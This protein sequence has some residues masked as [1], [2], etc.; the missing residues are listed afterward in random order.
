MATIGQD[1]RL[2][3]LSGGAGTGKSAFAAWLAHH[4]KVNV[5]GINL[6]RY[7]DDDRRDA[8]RVHP[9]ARLPDRDPAAGLSPAAARPAEKPGPRR[10]G[11][12][13]QEPRRTVCLAAG[14]AAR[15]APSTA[16]AARIA[17]WSSSMVS[18]RRCG[19]DAASLRKFCAADAQKLPA[20]IAVVVTSRPEEPIMRQFAGLQPVQI[21]AEVGGEP[22]GSA[23]LRPRMAG[24]AQPAGGA[25]SKPSRSHRERLRKAISFTCACCARR[26]RTGTLS[27]DTPE[28]LPQG[29]VG[30]YERWFRAHFPIAETYDSYV[31]LLAVIVAAEHPGPGAMADPDVR[32]VEARCGAHAGRSR[33]PVRAPDAG[34]A[35]F[36]KSLRDWL[37]DPK[38]AGADFVVDETE[39]TRT[40]RRRA[41]GGIPALGDKPD[42]GALDEFCVAE[43]PAQ[44]TRSPRMSAPVWQPGDGRRYGRAF[45]G[46]R[47]ARSR[48][49]WEHA[50]AWWGMA[51]RLAEPSGDAATR[52]KLMH[53]T[54]PATFCVT[55]GRSA[56]ALKSF[57]D[58]LA[59]SDRLAKADPG[60]AGWQR[61]LS[62][63][64]DK[65]GDVQVAQGNLPEALKSFRDGLAIAD[66]LAKADPGNAGWQRDLSVSLRQ[67]RRRAGGAGQSA[68]GAEIL[69]RRPRDSRPSGEGR[70]R[71]RRLAARSLGVATRRSAT[72]WWRRAICR[73]R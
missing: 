5:I 67:D 32:L 71:Q 37:I 44:M 18:T 34:V 49:A 61:D 3:W 70:P 11:A 38:A 69:P 68:G 64:Y 36:H 46:R 10:Q 65:I 4:G 54:R 15:L 35:P 22:G 52:T 58:G 21:E 19:T 7:N 1:S 48:Y 2:L 9:H 33:Q 13:A 51:A 8:G 47:D 6:C 72:C 59:I 30:L 57:R 50:L 24:H 20:W 53:Y 31:P 14:G 25:S 41:V 29:L 63:S 27:L 28:G 26:W 17:L 45:R 73:R 56:E 40:P 16:G 23:N 62:V 43:L 42:R 12:E 39:G 66:R 60:N 55:L